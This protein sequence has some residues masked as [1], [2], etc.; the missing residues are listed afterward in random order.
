VDEYDIY[1]RGFAADWPEAPELGLHRVFGLE[2]ARAR[3]L[4]ASLPRVVKRGVPGAEVERYAEALRALGADV[5]PRRSPIRPQAIVV[6]TGSAEHALEQ[7]HGSTLTLPPPAVV[8]AQAPRPVVPHAATVIGRASALAT[9]DTV[10]DSRAPIFDADDAVV[11]PARAPTYAEAPAPV[12][13]TRE[14]PSAT[15]Q[16]TPWSPAVASTATISETP[17]GARVVDDPMPAKPALPLERLASAVPALDWQPPPKLADAGAPAPHVAA[18]S[19]VA[20]LP[21]ASAWVAIEPAPLARSAQSPAPSART[22]WPTMDPGV[23]RYEQGDLPPPSAVPGLRADPNQWWVQGADKYAIDLEV[24]TRTSDRAASAPAG[25]VDAELASTRPR[26]NRPAPASPASRPFVQRVAVEER[27]EPSLVL[28]WLLRL[29]LGVSLFLVFSTV[30][31][32]RAVDRDIDRAL[33][34]WEAPSPDSA[35]RPP[36]GAG[37]NAELDAAAPIAS[38]WVKSDLHQFGNGDKDRVTALV[39]RFI[40]AG[41]VQVRIGHIMRSGL[42]QIGNELLIELPSD[43]DKRKAILAEYDRFMQSTFGSFAAKAKDPG[44]RMLRVTL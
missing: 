10:V 24:E 42:V 35:E 43:A 39:H 7:K 16:E 25:P 4:I 26:P 28:R 8:P 1:I 44:G 19:S 27:P 9:S 6:L 21:D 2:V 34:G 40:A 3:E 15:L 31:H 29:G 22:A 12:I 36:E 11:D 14:L 5:E 38:E 17:P 37:A 13:A 23:E 41:A 20:V 33:A 30:R 32:C 18:P